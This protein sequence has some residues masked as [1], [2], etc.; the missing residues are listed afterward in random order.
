MR[1]GWD[2]WLDFTFCLVGDLVGVYW[3][4]DLV[5]LGW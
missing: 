3:D 1:F 2:I 4:G 5:G